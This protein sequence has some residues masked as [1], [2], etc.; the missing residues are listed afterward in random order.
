MPRS[1]IW[2]CLMV[3]A[4]YCPELAGWGVCYGLVTQDPLCSGITPG[5]ALAGGSFGIQ[6]VPKSCSALLTRS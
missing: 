1:K 6:D 4:K 3:G 2:L 5:L